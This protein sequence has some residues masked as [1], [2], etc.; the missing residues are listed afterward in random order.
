VRSTRATDHDEAVGLTVALEQLGQRLD[1]H[2]G[3]L[4][5]LDPSDEEEEPPTERQTERAPGPKKA[6]STPGGTMRMRPGSP[7]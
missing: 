7:P 4:E 5:R 2:V 3:A 6:W 1:G